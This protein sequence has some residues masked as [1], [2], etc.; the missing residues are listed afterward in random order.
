MPGLA[1]EIAAQRFDAANPEFSRI[2]DAVQSRA[3]GVLESVSG[4]EAVRKVAETLGDN[5]SRWARDP[6]GAE[7]PAAIAEA[8]SR[9]TGWTLTHV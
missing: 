3:S 8:Q 2:L 1:P 5:W 9:A 7:S 6:L 4:G